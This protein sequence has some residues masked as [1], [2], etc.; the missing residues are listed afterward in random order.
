[1][2]VYPPKKPSHRSTLKFREP[3]DDSTCPCRFAAGT[4]FGQ[5]VLEGNQGF[6]NSLHQ[7]RPLVHQPRIHLH[8]R[9]AGFQFFDGIFGRGDAAHADDG[10]CAAGFLVEVADDFGGALPEGFAAEATVAQS[11]HFGGG[12]LQ[13]VPGDGGV[14]GDDAVH[15]CGLHDAEDVVELCVGEVGGDFEEEGLGSRFLAVQVLEMREE[16][17]W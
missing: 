4:F 8:E 13:P 16:T 6:V 5:S 2:T 17:S 12:S 15:T 3:Y 9:S 1:M 14:G 11:F 10:E 7:P